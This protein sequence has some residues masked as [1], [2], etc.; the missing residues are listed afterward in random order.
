[1]FS[2]SETMVREMKW[3]NII[4]QIDMGMPDAGGGMMGAEEGKIKPAKDME[5][6]REHPVD[7]AVAEEQDIENQLYGGQKKLDVNRDGKL[8]EEDFNQLREEK[9]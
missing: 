6:A 3:W 7:P 5:E 8:T 1:M 2:V 4:K 9:K